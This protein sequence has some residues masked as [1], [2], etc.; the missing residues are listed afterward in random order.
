MAENVFEG[1]GVSVCRR[2]MDFISSSLAHDD[3]GSPVCVSITL[4][5]L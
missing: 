2:E 4:E 3:L 5:V 1:Y